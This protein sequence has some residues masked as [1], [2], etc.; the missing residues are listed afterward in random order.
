LSSGFKI[1]SNGTMQPIWG[2]Q[3]KQLGQQQEIQT[4]KLQ[5]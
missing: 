1:T 4:G 3:S 5:I 2:R